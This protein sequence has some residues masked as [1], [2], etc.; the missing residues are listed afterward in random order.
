MSGGSEQAMNLRA[1]LAE[2]QARFNQLS[3]RERLLV[4][5]AGAA[6]SLFVLFLV[7]FS[8]SMS[9]DQTRRRIE[10]KLQKLEEAKTL[11]VGFREAEAAR[12]A[13][14]Q[15]LGQGEVR[16]ITYLEERGTEAGLDIPA[17]NPRGDTPLGDG[18]IIE[19]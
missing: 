5:V 9:A 8:L 7:F 14:E 12:Q 1:L 11:A 2:A 16:L 6:V 17:L 15:R 18:R 4:T 10:E 19:S 3:Q 13:A